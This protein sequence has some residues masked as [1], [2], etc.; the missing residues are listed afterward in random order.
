LRDR[1]KPDT[2]PKKYV[3]SRNIP[4]FVFPGEFHRLPGTGTT[5]DLGY[6]FNLENG[7]QSP[8]VVAEIG[9]RD[10]ELGEMSIALAEAL[11]G[12]NSNPRTGAGTPKGNIA[13]I[14]FPKSGRASA[15]PQTLEQIAIHATHLLEASGGAGAIVAC[16]NHL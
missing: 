1:S 14:I 2:D 12:T 3:D 11:G 5:G 6:A 16:R 15:W 4:Y 10:A 9:P 13:F 7:K 8:F